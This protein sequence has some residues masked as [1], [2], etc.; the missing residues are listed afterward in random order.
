MTE[1][2]RMRARGKKVGRRQHWESG[3]DNVSGAF[4]NIKIHIGLTRWLLHDDVKKILGR[5][6]REY[7]Q[8]SDHGLLQFGGKLRKLS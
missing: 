2:G 6:H 3:Q 4:N 5:L 7:I 1:W 8:Y